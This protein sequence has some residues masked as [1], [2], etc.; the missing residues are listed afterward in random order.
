MASNLFTLRNTRP[1]SITTK[2]AKPFYLFPISCI[3]QGIYSSVV[4]D[5][6]HENIRTL[7]HA[8]H[9]TVSIVTVTSED[10]LHDNHS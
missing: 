3:I 9:S 10:D 8:F 2:I 6:S 1:I 4:V 5:A 7:I